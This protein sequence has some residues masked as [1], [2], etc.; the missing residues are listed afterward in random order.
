MNRFQFRVQMPSV[1]KAGR[2]VWNYIMFMMGKN[3]FNQEFEKFNQGENG[4]FNRKKLKL[5]SN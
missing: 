4:C 1:D 2:Y 5:K 3:Q